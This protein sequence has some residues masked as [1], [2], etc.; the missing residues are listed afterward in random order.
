[1]RGSAAAGAKAPVLN[2][3]LINCAFGLP[4]ERL[5]IARTSSNRESTGHSVTNGCRLYEHSPS[6]HFGNM[7]LPSPNGIA[8]YSVSADR[9]SPPSVEDSLL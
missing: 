2:H 5:V 8:Q 9:A 1:M 3:A 6:P 4:D 7:K